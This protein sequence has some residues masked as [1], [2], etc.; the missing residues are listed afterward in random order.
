MQTLALFLA[1]AELD[2]VIKDGTTQIMAVALVIC[3]CGIIAS[4]FQLMK[5]EITYAI[6]ILLGSLT[7]GGSVA[8]ANAFFT[9][10]GVN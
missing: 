4:G 9:L 7:I 5:G 1:Q 8:I 3:I 10:A 6:Y 2:S